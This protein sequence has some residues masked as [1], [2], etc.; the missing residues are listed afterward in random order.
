M[1]G[2]S[3]LGCLL[4]F[5]VGILFVAGIV[6]SLVSMSV[7]GTG[8]I[9]HK[10][11]LQ[12]SFEKPILEQHSSNPLSRLVPFGLYQDDGL[13]YYDLVS[14]ID[15]AAADNRIDMIYLNTN[16]LSAGISQIEEIRNALKRFRTSG[17]P[18][19]AYADNY[20]QAGYYLA[21]VAD[22]VF[23]NP[24]GK[25]GLRGFSVTARYYK[26]LMDELGIE[27]QWIRHG[28][29]KTGGEHLTMLK[30]SQEERE[31][32]E[33]FLQSAWMHWTEEMAEAR[34]ISVQTINRLAE[35]NG[36]SQISEALSLT[37][38]DQSFYKD[39]LVD[40][41]C[42]LQ[43]VKSEKQLRILRMSTYISAK[44][45]PKAKAKVALLFAN[46][47]LHTGTGQQDI[48]SDNYIQT[49]RRLRADSS[50]KAVVLR[51]S[52][53]GGDARAA[54]IIHRELQLL[55]EQK[56]LVISVGDEAASGGYWISCAGD[57]I[58]A[59]PTSLTGSIGAYAIAYNGQKGLNKWLKVNAETVKTHSSSDMGSIYRPMTSL[60]LARI[61][62]DIDQTYQ[63]FVETV[64]TGR[65]RPYQEIDALAQGKI[66]SGIDAYNHQLID[67]IG[68]LTDAIAYAADLAG[69]GDYQVVEPMSK[70]SLFERLMQSSAG[71]Q[72][73]FWPGSNPADWAGEVERVLRQAADRGVQ[74]KLPFAY[75]LDY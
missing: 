48:M 33:Q 13:G 32:L 38:I 4:V 34:Q 14:A 50:V 17:K 9:P 61:Q 68:G 2:A 20:S 64:A 5:F 54:A 63:H 70:G 52:S 72:N 75:T 26:G 16:Y 22:K 11:I 51:V 29:H 30:M 56:P 37:L 42:T 62:Q 35:Q 39:G 43:S 21:S 19:I 18:V 27:A 1:L 47:S 25:I 12:I 40:Y 10:A 44:P 49:I 23:L 73:R 53:P 55:K 6:T 67:K 46:G 28:S 36:C 45:I 8:T 59:S 71:T 31:Q 15:R 7:S 66:W 41:F 74:T 57:H 69:L 60:E 3:I 65:E 24:H 58:F